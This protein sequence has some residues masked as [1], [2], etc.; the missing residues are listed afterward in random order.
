MIYNFHGPLDSFTPR[1]KSRAG[2]LGEG[3]NPPR[4]LTAGA[5]NCGA[6][7]W[8][9]SWHLQFGTFFP[10]CNLLHLKI[11]KMSDQLEFN[12]N[13]SAMKRTGRCALHLQNSAHRKVE[14]CA[15]RGKAAWVRLSSCSIPESSALILARC[16]RKL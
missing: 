12:E 10:N 9:I 7:L 14:E 11:K 4:H 13:I 1:D 15:R 2:V 5:C 3:K 8:P 6:T 16:R